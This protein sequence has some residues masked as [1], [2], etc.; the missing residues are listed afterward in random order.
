VISH[1]KNALRKVLGAFVWAPVTVMTPR[2]RSFLLTTE[3]RQLFRSSSV[4]RIANGV[5]EAFRV[6]PRGRPACNDGIVVE[7]PGDGVRNPDSTAQPISRYGLIVYE[8]DLYNNIGDDIQSTAAMAFL[9]TVDHLI[10]IHTLTSSAPRNSASGRVKVIMNGYFTCYPNAWP[11]PDWI[12]PLFVSIHLSAITYPLSTPSSGSE[13]RS[14]AEILLTGKNLEYFKRHEPIGCRDRVTVERFTSAGVQA[15]FT[16]CLTLTLKQ[17]W[18][19]S[20]EKIYVVDVNC[21]VSE[22]MKFV[23]RHL[24]ERVIVVTHNLPAP[25]RMSQIERVSSARELLMMY[26][27][28][29]L[30]ITSRLH[31]ALPCLALG[32]NVLFLEPRGDFDRLV[33][34]RELLNTITRDDIVSGRIDWENPPANPRRHLSLRDQL[35]TTCRSFVTRP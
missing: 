31:C 11:P 1:L 27:A 34:L 30:V 4:R 24:R 9:P 14:A 20:R 25:A 8:G 21:N 17:A 33:G 13:R 18:H 6:S 26:S 19:R 5:L 15:Y 10:P 35:D 7:A 16:G 12:E 23:P 28:A 3:L 32:T 2:R 22:I 29:K